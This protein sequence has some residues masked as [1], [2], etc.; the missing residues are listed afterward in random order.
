MLPR[1]ICQPIKKP[2]SKYITSR[3]RLYNYFY[4]KNGEKL[5]IYRSECIHKNYMLST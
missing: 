1:Q 4:I 2:A 5:N 3:L